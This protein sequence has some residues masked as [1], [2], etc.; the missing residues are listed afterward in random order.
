MKR[1]PGRI[2]AA[3]PAQPSGVS[4]KY[5][6]FF[7]KNN[8]EKWAPGL[9]A[10]RADITMEMVQRYLNAM[11]K[12]VDFVLTVTRDFVRNCQTPLLVLPDDVPAHPYATAMEMVHLAPNSQVS[13]FPWKDSKENIALAVR[14][15]RTFLRAH[16]PAE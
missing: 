9:V 10:S 14:H 13:L 7:I 2:V 12:G 6:D 8:L 11:Y 15:V 5:P 4:P 1:A 3:V 16:C